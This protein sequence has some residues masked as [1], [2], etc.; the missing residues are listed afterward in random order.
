MPATWSLWPWFLVEFQ[1]SS[2]AFFVNDWDCYRR[3]GGITTDSGK[4]ASCASRFLGFR[5]SN[6]QSPGWVQ[7]IKPSAQSRERVHSW[8][9][10]QVLGQRDRW[11]EGPC[12]GFIT[13]HVAFAMLDLPHSLAWI[14]NSEIDGD[15]IRLL[16]GVVDH[17]TST[18]MRYEH[19]LWTFGIA[20]PYSGDQA[21]PWADWWIV[22]HLWF[23]SPCCGRS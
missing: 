1:D 21:V 9:L 3:P 13:S 6:W 17:T 11:Y 23:S 18:T 19:H 16:G 22:L 12:S 5:A 15:S 2:A 20:W 8:S 14:F 7:A 4:R 10:Q